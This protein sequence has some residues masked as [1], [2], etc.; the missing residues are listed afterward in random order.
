M[1][2]AILHNQQKFERLAEFSLDNAMIEIER[3][4]QLKETSANNRPSEEQQDATSITL[5]EKAKGKLPEG[6]LSRVSSTSSISQQQQNN[7]M[8]SRQ[9][10]LSSIASTASL[11]PGV[12]N[13]FTPTDDWVSFYN[14][15]NIYYITY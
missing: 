2:L 1:I 12:K 3:L 10:S 9:V 4:R 15:L 14:Q 5:S 7:N 8:P 11:L 13:G 6:S